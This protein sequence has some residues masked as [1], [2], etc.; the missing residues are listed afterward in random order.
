MAK[1][2]AKVDKMMCLACGGCISVCPQD[3]LS[4]CAGKAFVNE[5][6]CT[7]CAV[8]IRICPVGAI[9]GEVV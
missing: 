2:K 9:T 7:C 4:M 1:P 5:K 8:C 3:A 6:N